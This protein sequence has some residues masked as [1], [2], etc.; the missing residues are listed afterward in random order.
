M[1][2]NIEEIDGINWDILVPL[3]R[4]QRQAWR[5]VEIKIMFDEV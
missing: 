4:W 3:S 5:T 1:G 2:D